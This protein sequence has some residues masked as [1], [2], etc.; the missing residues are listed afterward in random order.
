MCIV[1]NI[2][3]RYG[4]CDESFDENYSMERIQNHEH[5]VKISIPL[6]VLLF[7]QK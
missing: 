1:H 4:N 2:Q 6:D 7:I 3:S 5:P